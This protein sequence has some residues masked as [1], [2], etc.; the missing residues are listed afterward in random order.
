[1]APFTPSCL[2]DRKRDWA[3]PLLRLEDEIHER[4]SCIITA[5]FSVRMAAVTFIF[6]AKS[7]QAKH[8]NAVEALFKEGQ[9][10]SGSSNSFSR[11]A[12]T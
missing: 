10:A 1:M 7:S 6:L 2:E 9:I 4:S 5:R 12:L 3:H 11:I 8:L